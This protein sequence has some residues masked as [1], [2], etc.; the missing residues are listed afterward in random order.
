MKL[1][2]AILASALTL[3]LGIMNIYPNQIPEYKVEHVSLEEGISN[4]MIFSICQDSKGFIWYGTM[5]GL[6]RYDGVNYKTIR[7]NPADS[8]SISNDDVISICEDKSGYLWIGTYSGGLNRYDPGSGKF[9]RFIYSPE[10]PGAISS[11][12]VWKILQDRSG[13]MWFGTEGGGLC[14]YENEHFTSYKRDSLN[15][16]SIGGNRIFSLIEDSEGNIWAGTAGGGLSRYNRQSNYFTRYTPN[17]DDNSSISSGIVRSLFIDKD[18]TLWAGTLNKGLNKFDKALNKFIRY[19]NNFPDK[20]TSGGKNSIFSIMNDPGN[21]ED[22][23]L[24]TGR[25]FYRFNK[26]LNNFSRIWIYDSLSKKQESVVTSL[27]DNSGVM[28]LSTYFDG[29]HKIYKNRDKFLTY[30]ASGL[31]NGK[32]LSSPNVKCFCED[33]NGNIWIGTSNGLNKLDT[34]GNFTYY[35]SAPAGKN[36]ISGNVVNSIACDKDGNL[37]IGT[38]NGLNKFNINEGVIEKYYNNPGDSTSL[39]SNV[40]TRLLITRDNTLWAGTNTGLNKYLAAEKRFKRFVNDRTDTATLSENSVLSMYEDKNNNL[41]IG[42]YAGLNRLNKDSKT[43]SHYKKNINDTGSLSNNYVFSFCEGSDDKI[44][45]GTGGGLNEFD[46]SSGRF[47]Y[48]LEKDGL[49]NSVICGIEKDAAGNL[50]LSSKK[51]LSR[52]NSANKTFSN[53]SAND[54]L[55]SNMFTEGAYYKLA[56]GE[57]LFGGIAGFNR[58]DPVNVTVSN[59]KAPMLL[60]ALTKFHGNEKT[61]IDISKVKEIELAYNDNVLTIEFSSLD[62]TNPS[63]NKYAYMLEGFEDTWNYTGNSPRAAFTNL[64]PGTYTFRVKG[65]NSDGVWN[66]EGASLI[67]HIKPPFWKTWW[68]YLII[69]AVTV[70]LVIAVHNLRVRQKVANLLQIEKAKE[71]E[72][73]ILREQASRDYHDELGHK[74]TRISI[75]SKR[76]KK[77]LG[78]SAN[79][80]TSDLIGIVDTSQS[81]QSGAKDLIWSLNPHEDSLYDFSVRL[82]DFGNE[83]F[84]NTGID[85]SMKG[86]R[87]DFKNLKLSMQ[88]KRHLIFIFKEAMNN[89]LKYS[90][91]RNV[92]I[93]INL[94]NNILEI[95]LEDDGVGFTLSNDLKG[96]GLKNIYNRTKKVNG[97]VEIDSVLNKGTKITFNVGI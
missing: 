55:Q 37:W 29:L 61:E 35:F 39:T 95:A 51:G 81:L 74:L 80:I 28:W 23:L 91:C 65:T 90:D 60:T 75:H 5:F 97:N 48:Y 92:R 43:F 10:N 89:A 66:N 6:V 49:P 22:L 79:G 70:L 44:W 45:V 88:N 19:Q 62:Y 16:S 94:K 38:D 34:N 26:T 24:S 8:N 78:S 83:I 93:D 12:T 57:I 84:E 67:I 41:W 36:T 69:I 59:F 87:D 4:N 86:I 31:Q 64:D 82:K 33:N 14:K 50:W 47:T 85:F 56:G 15:P 30:G 77:K 18:G 53:F 3:L 17:P 1:C 21:T 71:T 52:F 11:N 68:F 76:I 9:K 27:T 96:Y 73:E 54:G 13:V 63:K 2:L 40:I 32:D 25:G 72:R 58:I 20:D 42:T 46:V 7:N